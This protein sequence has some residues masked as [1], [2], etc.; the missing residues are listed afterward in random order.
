MIERNLILL[1]EKIKQAC[2]TY[3][4]NS[5]QVNLIA[6]SKKF[7]VEEIE[8]AINAG[9]KIFGENYLK[10][11]EEKWPLIR[12]KNPEIKLHFIGHLQSNK[13]AQAVELFDSIQ[14]LDSEKLALVLKKESEKQ[15]KNPEIFIQVNIG[16]EPQKHGVMPLEVADFVRFSRDDLGLNI[17]G[18]M[19]IPPSEELASPYFALLAKL[20]KE[21]DLKNLSMG[22]SSDFVEA[23]ALGA[24]HIR[25]GTAIF[26]SR[27]LASQK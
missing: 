16:E 25:L 6:V 1:N 4:R 5:S 3:S 17:V 24:T 26:G 2:K 23:I 10:E 21:N 11:A 13:A 7:G 12:Q 8:Q 14:T 20:A 27:L 15:K 9:C 18:L 19:C 22:M